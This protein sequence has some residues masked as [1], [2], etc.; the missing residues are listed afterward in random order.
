MKNYIKENVNT[1]VCMYVCVCVLRLSRH[2]MIQPFI[3]QNHP[4]ILLAILAV[5][6]FVERILDVGCLL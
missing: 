3:T 5:S 4:F 1:R 2:K 6:I